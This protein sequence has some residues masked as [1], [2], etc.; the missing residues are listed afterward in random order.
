MATAKKS[1]AKKSAAE[2]PKKEKKSPPKMKKMVVKQPA[3]AV[4]EELFENDS[5]DFAF[6]FAAPFSH[7]FASKD[8][9]LLKL[10]I[11]AFYLYSLSFALSGINIYGSAFFTALGDGLVSAIISFLRMFLFQVIAISILPLFLGIDGIWLSVVFV[12]IASFIVVVSFFMAFRKK[13]G[14]G[15]EREAAL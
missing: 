12:E 5:K 7:I 3:A 10:T 6:A 1:T 11:R 4:E 8:E 2:T 13:Y 14:Y 9:A 15:K